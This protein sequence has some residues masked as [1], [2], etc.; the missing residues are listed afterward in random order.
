MFVVFLLE[1]SH[2]DL[3]QIGMEKKQEGDQSSQIKP[4]E[5]TATTGETTRGLIGHFSSLP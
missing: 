3:R 1:L 5:E 4:K 2:D